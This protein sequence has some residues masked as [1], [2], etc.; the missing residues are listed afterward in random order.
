MTSLADTRR[1]YSY[2]QLNRDQLDADPFKQLQG[3]LQ[4]AQEAD[5]KDATVMTLAT[6]GKNSMPDARIVMLKQ[7]DKKG[8]CWYTNYESK[9]GHQLAE[10]PQACLLFYWRDFDRQV[11]IRGRVEKLPAQDAD[12][13]FHSRPLESQFSAAASSQSQPI[14]SRKALEDKLARLKQ[15]NP[16][17]IERPKNWGGYRLIPAEFEFWQ[18][19]SGRLHDRFNYSLMENGKWQITR[20]QP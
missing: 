15:Q 18:G 12:Q 19:R 16:N 7:L 1:E 6:S 8:L 17:A 13:Y 14:E 5:L 3:W 4:Q 9:K 20:L 2:T 10:N 11:V